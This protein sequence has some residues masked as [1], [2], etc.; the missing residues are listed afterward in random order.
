MLDNQL[1]AGM[2]KNCIVVV[3]EPIF[4]VYFQK[5]KGIPDKRMVDHNRTFVLPSAHILPT[6]EEA[7]TAYENEGGHLS[8]P[9][10]FGIDLLTG[11]PELQKLRSD[12]FNA[13]YPSFDFFFHSLVNGNHHPFQQGLSFF[14]DQTTSLN[15]N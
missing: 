7:V 4:F 15:P 3:I 2:C 8:R 9:E 5:G 11:H 14:I 6:S 10:V 13:V 12:N 1:F